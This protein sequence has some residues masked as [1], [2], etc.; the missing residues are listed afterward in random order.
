MAGALPA[1]GVVGTCPDEADDWM[2][3]MVDHHSQLQLPSWSI[4]RGETWGNPIP[5]SWQVVRNSKEKAGDF[6]PRNMT[7]ASRKQ[8]E[9]EALDDFGIWGF[10]KFNIQYSKA[11]LYLIY[12]DILFQVVIL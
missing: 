1:P 2:I 11:D 8:T 10:R 5:D 6:C 3:P 12:F 9:H 4:S 7:P